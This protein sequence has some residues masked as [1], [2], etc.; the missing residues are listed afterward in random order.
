MFGIKHTRI[1]QNSE[2][3]ELEASVAELQESHKENKI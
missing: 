2:L 3:S 1:F